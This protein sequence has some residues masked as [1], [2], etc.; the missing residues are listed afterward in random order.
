ML[1]ERIE[2]VSD[3]LYSLTMRSEPQEA[4]LLYEVLNTNL[5]G[6]LNGQMISINYHRLVERLEKG[7]TSR[8]EVEEPQRSAEEMTTI[9][10]I[11][12]K[13]F[14]RTFFTSQTSP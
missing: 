8:P 3:R 7:C 10:L 5:N 9:H 14:R 1:Y 6:S 4:M 12:R 11:R 13:S 2:V